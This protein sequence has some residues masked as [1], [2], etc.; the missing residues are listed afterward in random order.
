MLS[1]TGVFRSGRRNGLVRTGLIGYGYWGPKLARCM[2][3]DTG[4]ALGTVCD[5][6]A[7]RL[8]AA[9]AD[10][11]HVI[12]QRDW[13]K[14]LGDPQIDAIVIATPANSHRDL[15]LAALDAGKH[16]LVEKPMALSSSN[17]STMIAAAR[18][19]NLV[20]LV[21]HT[22]VHS[23]AM[24]AIRRALSQGS[25]GQIREY[26]SLRYN[27]EGGR[28]DADVLWDL[29][30]HDLSILEFLFP[31]AAQA[32]RVEESAR[33]D[34]GAPSRAAL[35]VYFPDSLVARIRVDWAA[36]ERR[37]RIE[38]AGTKG[39]LVFDDLQAVKLRRVDQLNSE[40]QGAPP[41]PL[42]TAEPLTMVIRHFAACIRGEEEPAA[43]SKAALR[44][45][46]LLEAASASLDHG[47]SVI[48]LDAADHRLA[49]PAE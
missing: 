26:R 33:T 45:I 35:T 5:L 4:C 47:G 3:P 17:A 34:G 42:E 18:R 15:A 29:A 9:A 27:A 10:H 36:G 46:R 28:R 8:G 43:G 21:D 32:V 30:A 14:L 39:M 6:S 2:A 44:V 16:V 24:Q 31:G 25:L 22:Y 38:I 41:I 20:L 1:V 49:L 23:P 12:T 40:P 19:R 37:R 48:T 7:E 11:P 13:R